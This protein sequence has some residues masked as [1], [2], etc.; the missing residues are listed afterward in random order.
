MAMAVRSR[1]LVMVFNGK[2]ADTSWAVESTS[3]SRPSES[4]P[5]GVSLGAAS[6]TTIR[7]TTMAK[8]SSGELSRRRIGARIILITA[9]A[10]GE[11]VWLE[12]PDSLSNEDMQQGQCNCA[13][14]D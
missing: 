1:D 8:C 10:P 14:G 9:D 3:L 4:F 13:S 6:S 5:S 11:A 7:T 2:A 12:A